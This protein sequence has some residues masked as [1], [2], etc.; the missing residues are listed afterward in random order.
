[1][2]R[3]R[4]R[5]FHS[6]GLLPDAV[7]V[8]PATAKLASSAEASF[9]EWLHSKGL[10]SQLELLLLAPALLDLCIVAFGRDLW[11]SGQPLY[12]LLHLLAHFQ[13]VRPQLRHRLPRS[14]TTVTIW[15]DEEPV[16]H[17]PPLPETLMLAMVSASLALGWSHFGAALL[18]AFDGIARVG[19]WVCATR[20]Q[21]LLPSDVL[22]GDND[23]AYLV[24]LSP[25]TSR[26]G[27]GRSQH[28]LISGTRAVN[29][30]EKTFAGSA[31]GLS[32]LCGGARRFRAG[33]DALLEAFGVPASLGL[34]PGGIRGGGAIAAYR[35]GAHIEDIRWRMRIG[36]QKT[37]AHYL[38]EAMA[39]EVMP[40]LSQDTRDKIQA[41]AKLAQTLLP[42]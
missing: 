3:G 14:W 11:S 29:L 38:Q 31:P 34:V 1:M 19:E 24:V 21:L 5:L 27:G 8:Q 6:R 28:V 35:R 39:M 7:Q 10:C 32:L 26:R 9:R 20:G 33:W 23:R 36:D 25:K 13:R 22:S 42:I 4:P 18:A 40:K 17:R 16:V 41:G 12:W 37:L 15:E 2:P 30:L